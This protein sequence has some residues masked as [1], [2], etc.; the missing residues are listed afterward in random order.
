VSRRE[1]IDRSE[2]LVNELPK[3]R[4]LGDSCPNE[5]DGGGWKP[6]EPTRR[7]KAMTKL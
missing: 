3:R 6:N 7:R 2:R 4:S 5:G 1:L